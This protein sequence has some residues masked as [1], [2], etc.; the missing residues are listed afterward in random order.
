MYGPTI[1][2]DK[3]EALMVSKETLKGGGMGRCPIDSYI[4]TCVPVQFT[5]YRLLILSVIFSYLDK[6]VNQERRNRNLPPLTIEVINVISPTET[7]VDEVSLK[8]SS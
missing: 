8:I 7:Q 2:D 1:T 3:L 5:L 6:I 4:Q